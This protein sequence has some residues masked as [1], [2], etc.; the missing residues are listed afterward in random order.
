V[1]LL[2][3]GANVVGA[4]PD[5]WWRD[6]AAAA[7]RLHQALGSWLVGGGAEA[8]VLVLEGAARAGVPA[9]P[10]PS[11]GAEPAVQVA[12][13]TGSGDDLLRTLAAP[14]WTAVTADRALAAD[15]RRLGCEV[16]GPSWLWAQL[17]AEGPGRSQPR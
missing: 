1:R 15:L 17:P 14:G 11:P 8:V 4:R 7:A 6:R 5:G 2:V 3:D 10:L 13:A 9:T 12:H 16:R